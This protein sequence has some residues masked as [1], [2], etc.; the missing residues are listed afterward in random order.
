[1]PDNLTRDIK[2]N[3]LRYPKRTKTRR[4]EFGEDKGK[5]DAVGI[6]QTPFVNTSRSGPV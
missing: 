5:N 4:I 2:Q 1:M 6:D 3:D